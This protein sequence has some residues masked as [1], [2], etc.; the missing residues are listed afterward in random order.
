MAGE[1]LFLP[2]TGGSS[3][4]LSPLRGSR[5]IPTHMEAR[6]GKLAELPPPLCLVSAR[7]PQRQLLRKPQNKQGSSCSVS[8]TGCG[9]LR[10]SLKNPGGGDVAQ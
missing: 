6:A 2:L 7:I 4:T 8:A 5:Q 10:Q 9:F 3:A 1:G